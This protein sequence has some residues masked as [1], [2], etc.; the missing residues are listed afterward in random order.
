MEHHD[1]IDLT[2][3]LQ[4]AISIP[5]RIEML[6]RAVIECGII[7]TIVG[8]TNAALLIRLLAPN[9]RGSTVCVPSTVSTAVPTAVP[10]C[11]CGAT[12]SARTKTGRCR[13]CALDHR[14]KKHAIATSALAASSAHT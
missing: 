8:V 6:E 14:A 2:S 12:I 11:A 3:V 5:Q 10:F 4:T 7:L 9:T 13:A 1:A